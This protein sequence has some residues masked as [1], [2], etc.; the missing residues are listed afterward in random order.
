MVFREGEAQQLIEILTEKAGIVQDT[1]HAVGL[2]AAS[3]PPGLG[4]ASGGAE[5]RRQPV[6]GQAVPRGSAL[7][8]GAEFSP[9][10]EGRTL[11]VWGGGVGCG[12][13]GPR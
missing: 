8:M 6:F 9:G 4:Q 2:P 1:W 12:G 3:C 10:A 13:G 5:G 11:C 7:E